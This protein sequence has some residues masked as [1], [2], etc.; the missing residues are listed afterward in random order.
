MSSKARFLMPFEYS[1]HCTVLILFYWMHLLLVNPLSM[2]VPLR[3]EALVLR[4][5]DE[6]NLWNLESE[7]RAKDSLYQRAILSSIHC[8]LMLVRCTQVCT[9]E[10]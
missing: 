10:A 8:S 7:P 1:L 3:L 4:L 5:E 2:P 6:R 9:H